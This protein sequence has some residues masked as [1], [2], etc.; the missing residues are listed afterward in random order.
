[1]VCV[2]FNLPPK[3]VESFFNFSTSSQCINGSAALPMFCVSHS[4]FTAFMRTALKYRSRSMGCG[5]QLLSSISVDTTVATI[6]VDI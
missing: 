3:T 2:C 5:T 4:K 6:T 1:M